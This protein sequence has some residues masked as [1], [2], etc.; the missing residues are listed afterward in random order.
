M[1]HLLAFE[2]HAALI[3]KARTQFRGNMPAA[4]TSSAAYRPD[5]D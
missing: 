4:T 5:L 2:F 3:V 1:K